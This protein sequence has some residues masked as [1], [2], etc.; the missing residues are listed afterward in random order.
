MRARLINA[1]DRLGQRGSIKRPALV[2]ILL[3]PSSFLRIEKLR[4]NKNRTSF[5][6]KSKNLQRSDSRSR[7]SGLLILFLAKQRRHW[8]RLDRRKLYIYMLKKMHKNIESPERSCLLKYNLIKIM[9]YN[10]EIDLKW[11]LGAI[12]KVTT[13]ESTIRTVGECNWGWWAGLRLHPDTSPIQ[14]PQ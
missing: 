14:P 9:V 6:S 10:Y 8:P 4:K 7:L 5:E 12:F 3:L 11:I 13:E 2:K 1:R